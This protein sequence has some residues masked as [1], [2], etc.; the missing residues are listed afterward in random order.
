MY[1]LIIHVAP[2]RISAATYHYLKGFLEAYFRNKQLQNYCGILT[3]GYGG[4]DQLDYLAIYS[5]GYLDV[6]LY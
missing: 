6:Y 3:L 5:P 1:F 2:G 4:P